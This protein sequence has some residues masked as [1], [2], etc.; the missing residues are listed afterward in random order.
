VTEQRKRDQDAASEGRERLIEAAARLFTE[1]NYTD[2]AIH[3]IAEAAG[4]TRSAPYYHFRNKEELYAA[5]IQ[6]QL[7]SIADRVHEELTSAATFREQ[8][9]AIVDVVVEM[10]STPYGRFVSDFRRHLSPEQQR[11]IMDRV[12]NA[13]DLYLPVF[14]AAHARGEFHRTTPE[15]A[16]QIF[17]VLLIGYTESR[18]HG[19]RFLLHGEQP[20]TADQLLDAFLGGI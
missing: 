14:A 16:T 8:L 12:P 1:R 15:A 20:L 19:G 7:I 18:H 17:F 4:M 11:A 10:A 2:V 6:R 9:N 13:R 3:E 5:V